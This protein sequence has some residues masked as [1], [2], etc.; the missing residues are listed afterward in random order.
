MPV[1]H[2]LRGNKNPTQV[3]S[4]EERGREWTG[5]KRQKDSTC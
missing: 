3:G 2:L 5:N 1:R 4:R